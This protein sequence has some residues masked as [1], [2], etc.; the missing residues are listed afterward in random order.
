MYPCQR[1]GGK[2]EKEAEGGKRWRKGD[3]ERIKW[4]EREKRW[5][6]IS[7][8]LSTC[9]CVNISCAETTRILLVK[10]S[11]TVKKI[12]PCISHVLFANK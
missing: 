9:I 10:K 5:K 6:G 8:A 4:R 3:E 11:R 7:F 1:K 2:K 12:S